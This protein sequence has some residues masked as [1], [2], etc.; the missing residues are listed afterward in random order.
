MFKNYM[1]VSKIKR[2]SMFSM[3]C[4]L[5]DF[6]SVSHNINSKFFLKGQSKII[7]KKKLWAI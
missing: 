7:R 2:K 1:N 4:K 6:K 3:Q 5:I